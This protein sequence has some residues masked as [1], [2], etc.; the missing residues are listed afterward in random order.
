VADRIEGAIAGALDPF[1]GVDVYVATTLA[2]VEL[3]SVQVGLLVAPSGGALTVELRNAGSALATITVADGALSGAFTGAVAIASG[4]PLYLRVTASPG[5]P[6]D[7][8]AALGFDA[9]LALTTVAR[10]KEYRRITTSAHDGQLAELVEGVSRALES[11]VGRPLVQRSHTAE[12]RHGNGWN[13]LV[14]DHW[15]VIGTPV[16]RVDGSAIAEGTDFRVRAD[17]GILERIAGDDSAWACWEGDIEV[18]YV[19]GYATIPADLRLAA[20]KQVVHEFSQT[21]A[22]GGRLGVTATASERGGQATYEP[23]G[24]LASVRAVLDRYREV[25]ARGD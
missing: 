18:D 5:D 19:S 21:T 8:R 17:W 20:T 10:V 9:D 11:Y 15:P 4:T 1:V 7:L 25:V 6:S 2:D 22:G 3:A 14:L 16:V 23:D 24:L 12:R 13:E